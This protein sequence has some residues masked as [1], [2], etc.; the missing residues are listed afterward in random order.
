M[1]T[2]G[3]AYQAVIGFAAVGLLVSLVPSI[4]GQTSQ[5][6]QVRITTDPTDAVV[7]CDG[8]TQD[9]PPLTI[10]GLAPGEHLIVATKTGYQE[11]RRTIT[12]E[13]GECL[14]VDLKL[15]PICGIVLVHSSPPGA[16]V[17]VNGA[18][19]GKTPLLLTD[20]PLGSYRLKISAPGYLTKE[21]ELKLESRVPTKVEASLRSDTATLVVT[22]E[23]PGARLLLNGADRGTTP[24]T[25]DRIREGDCRVELLLD[26]YEPYIRE[27][28]LAAGQTESLN[29]VLKPLPAE[30]TVVSIPARAR[31][32]VDNQFSGEA[33]VV[34]K[35][36]E[37]G[38]YRIRAE[39]TGHE[40]LVRTVTLG[41][42]QR[43]VEEFRLERNTGN[44]EI[45][46]EPAGVRV[47]LD[48]QEAG[49]TAAQPDQSDQ[50]SDPLRIEMLSAG[51]HQLKL[52]RKGYYE[53]ARPV[54][55]EKDKTTTVHEK[56]KR[57]FVPDYEVRTP[58]E[59][60][61]GVLLQI[62]PNG[63]VKI[64]L[65]PGIIRT[66]PAAEIRSKGPIQEQTD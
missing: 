12:L 40:P 14:A 26:G 2:E 34:L 41:R 43:L 64:E 51:T 59:V 33:P 63:N 42:A 45:V 36:L 37:P 46:T 21:I 65:R 60:V 7:L 3:R 17:E 54:E 50:I 52:V 35:N 4:W 11:E 53:I 13:P 16:E 31:I 9:P 61:R 28:R 5:P 66:I 24:C 62:E 48:G 6:T 10:R 58:T 38:S 19:R 18:S 29:I 47:F 27:L 8:V 32:Y 55:I 30:L 57:R 39:L 1:K 15:Q 23:P 49:M 25:V 20:L 22:S 44:L 56:L